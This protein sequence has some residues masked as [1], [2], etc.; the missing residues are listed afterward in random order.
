MNFLRLNHA[1]RSSNNT[2]YQRKP[3][4]K[5]EQA[6]VNAANKKYIHHLGVAGYT[7]LIKKWQKM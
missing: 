3:K 2:N 4:K 6:K 1:G 7:K 5:S